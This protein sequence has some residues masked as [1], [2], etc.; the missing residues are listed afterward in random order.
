LAIT[1]AVPSLS[2]EVGHLSQ[3]LRTLELH[4]P[5]TGPTG[6]PGPQGPSGATGAT[7]AQGPKGD[8][9]ATGPAGATGATGPQGATGATGPQGPVGPASL[10]VQVDQIWHS[11]PFTPAGAWSF[12][13]PFKSKV[14][15]AL[16]MTF[17]ANSLALT[18]WQPKVDGVGYSPY[19]DL[20]FNATSY[21]QTAFTAFTIASCAAGTHSISYASISGSPLSDSMDRAHWALTFVEI[22]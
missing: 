21:H 6:P 7:G 19:C 18:G 20:Y 16:S 22:P 1:P 8:T 10:R 15:V 14:L 5:G 3:R 2:G 13:A 17:Y 12:S 4:P 11:G 9:G